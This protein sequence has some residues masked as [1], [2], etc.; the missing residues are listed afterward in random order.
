MPVFEIN[1]RKPVFGKNTWIAPTAEIIGDV[2][3]ADNCYIGYGAI[4]R[5]DYG[6][7]I[8][9]PG[10][11]IEEGVMIH[12]RPGD[13]TEIGSNVTVGHR[14][15]LHNTTIEDYAVIGMNSTVTDFSVVGQWSIIGEQ[16]LVKRNQ[17]I[18]PGKI[19]GGV[20]ASEIKDVEEKN[21]S[22][23]L[24]AK[25]VYVELAKQNLK[26]LKDITCNYDFRYQED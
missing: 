20:P 8:I 25:K 23:W 4:L 12:A 15:M 6:T 19:Y 2:R 22:E 5:G 7:I 14:A 3:I 21:R 13:K 24:L 16:S 1:G 26:G 17:Q 9:G 18:P 10:T 11:A